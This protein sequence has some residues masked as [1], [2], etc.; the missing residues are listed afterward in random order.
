MRIG[1]VL[2]FA[3]LAAV[4]VV[5]ALPR[6]V[7]TVE[8]QSFEFTNF[9][10]AQTNPLRLSPDGTRLFAVNTS[11]GSLSVFDISE[12]AFPVLRGEIPVGLEPVSVNPRSNDE[13]WVVNQ[14]SDSVSVVSVSRGLVVD[15]LFTGDEPMDVVF[16]GENQAY[17]SV[18]R[19]NAIAV[20]DTD[21]RA[22]IRFLPVFG[23]NPRALAVSRD[24][25]TVYA[26]F[27]LSG[28]ATTLITPNRAP[29]QPPP[30]NGALP[31]PPN[32]GKI[33][34][35]SDR[36]W[37]RLVPYRMP[38][39]DVAIIAARPI[40]VVAGYYSGVGTVNLGLAVNPVNGDL[41]V[42]NTDARNLVQFEP[43]LR[44]HWVD[45]RL[46]RI[47]VTSSRVTPFDLNPTI[48]YSILP[49]PAAR[50][51][52]LAQPTSVVFDPGGQ[53]MY[54]AAFGTDRVALVD[55]EGTVLSFIEV[56]PQSGSGANIDPRTKRG[57]RALALDAA[58]RT[59]Y[60]LNRISNTISVID[61][62]QRTVLR[63]I[64][65]GAD[66]TPPL[67]RRGRG[68]L[69]DAKLSGNGTGSCASCHIDGD[70][71]HL[72]WDLG[73]PG[74][75]MITVRQGRQTIELHPMKGP[76]TTQTLRGLA[77]LSPFH[78]RGDKAT[79]L[80]FNAAF[81]SLMG[82]SQVSASDMLTFTTF[83]NSMVFQPNPNQNLDRSLPTAFRGGNAV[84]GR[85]VFLTLRQ[86]ILP[87][88][89]TCNQCHK[90]DP[91]PGTN[92]LIVSQ[93]D[94]MMKTPHHRNIYQRVLF[95]RYA[96]ENID[97][98]G[99]DHDGHVSGLFEFFAAP[100]FVY[101]QQQ[102]TDMT[103]YLMA[104]DTGTAPAVGFTITLTAGIVDR[105]EVQTAWSTLQQQSI[106]RN[107][108]LV[109]RGTIDGQ[110][111]ALSYR[112]VLDDYVLDAFP[113]ISF[114]RA[115]LQSLVERGDTLSIMGVPPRA[116]TVKAPDIPAPAV[117]ST[118]RGH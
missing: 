63:E 46:T 72:A 53:F 103:A 94:Q 3:V 71:D 59:L 9:E 28:N 90:A 44:G 40:P 60:V 73:D 93:P 39:N 66:P 98:F 80:D 22:L 112:P 118:S 67:I 38:D 61:T 75:D 74:G 24:G 12:P 19:S 76:M 62:V 6:S 86:S 29:P 87:I 34:S 54:V 25:T 101:T 7:T 107:I 100:V 27:A 47:D 37:S 104:F 55:T 79:F 111:R 13:A 16:A 82:G 8:G 105:P 41:F 88:P 109:V 17:V 18:S 14:V 97:G 70:M 30:T 117:S 56:G 52:A 33:V 64:P 83:V 68:F 113:L 108:D 96:D 21:T 92:R 45:N 15:T 51:T 106:V 65:V 78:W 2:T 57:P 50:A 36:R 77:G 91:G 10:G 31:P 5:I 32:A 4:A 110:V 43:N 84:A 81:D 89:M 49:N 114:S 58:A 102:K 99:L 48:N 85:E 23:G 20:F 35:A 69:Y 115:D 11:N 26:A 95:N 1:R 116:A 42:A